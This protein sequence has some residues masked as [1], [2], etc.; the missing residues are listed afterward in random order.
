MNH[1]NMNQQIMREKILVA[2]EGLIEVLIERL[3]TTVDLE[4]LKKDGYLN[5]KEAAAFLEVSQRSVHRYKTLGLIEHKK[6]SGIIYFKHSSLH[7]FKEHE[8]IKLA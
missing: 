4:P 3:S 1:P 2:L 5:I 6:I 8:Q 7:H